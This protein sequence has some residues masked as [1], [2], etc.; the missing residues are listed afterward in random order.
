[1]HRVLTVPFSPATAKQVAD[2]ENV[3]GVEYVPNIDVG[4]DIDQRIGT[5]VAKL[6]IEQPPTS[7]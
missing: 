5:V 6:E 3:A 2:I 7:A 4:V 1:M